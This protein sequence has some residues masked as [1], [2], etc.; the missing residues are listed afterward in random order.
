MNRIKPL[1][2]KELEKQVAEAH[3]VSLDA[4]IKCVSKVLKHKNSY[5]PIVVAYASYILSVCYLYQARYEEANKVLQ[6]IVLNYLKYPFKPF[7]VD[8]FTVLGGL[9][10]SN[11]NYYLSLFYFETGLRIAQKHRCDSSFPQIYSNMGATYGAIK[12]YDK[13][14]ECFKKVLEYPSIVSQADDTYFHLNCSLSTIAVET[15]DYDTAEKYYEKAFDY[16]KGHFDADCQAYLKILKARILQGQGKEE[17]LKQLLNELSNPDKKPWN[18][19]LMQLSGYQDMCRVAIDAKDEKLFN[20][21]L[22]AYHAIETSGESLIGDLSLVAMEGEM[23]YLQQDYKKAAEKFRQRYELG[24]K[25]A[26]KAENNFESAI[27][28]RLALAELAKNYQIT[29]K[30]NRDLKNESETDSLTKI[31]NRH[32][33]NRTEAAFNKKMSSFSSFGLAMVDFDSFKSINDTYGHLCGDKALRALGNSLK[34]IDDKNIRSFRYG[35]DEFVLVFLNQ[36]D[37]EVLS[38][39]KRIQAELASTLLVGDD[40]RSP[41]LTISAGIYN[42]K[43]PKGIITEYISKADKALY[44]AKN[45]G[46][47]SIQFFAD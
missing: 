23:A 34:R 3:A 19:S 15:K 31:Y 42:Q 1:T 16:I 18:Q 47:N 45:N 13:A 41:S 6:P 8:A 5:S 39:L 2:L 11:E 9:A 35:G 22:E 46:K 4:V 36:T 26:R 17:E 44:L 24:D 14:E 40:G 28:A 12:Q 27:S 43:A 10:M 30:Q 32:A 25:T 21:Y 29:K 37:E 20:T 7:I 33:F 38:I